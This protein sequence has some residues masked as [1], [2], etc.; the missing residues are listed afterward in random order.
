M[1]RP[2]LLVVDRDLD[3]LARTEGELARRFGADFRVRGESD[4]TVALEQLRLAA[5]RRDPV[6]LVLADPWL[7][8]VGGAELLRSV[9]TLHPD[10]ARALLVP[11]GAWA[12]RRTADEILRG[13][14][15]GDIDYY[16]LEPWSSPDE[17]FCRTVSEFVQVWSR[18]VENRRREVVVV[19]AAREPRGHAV[20]SLLTRNGIPHAYLDRGTP[21]AVAVLRSVEAPEPTSEDGPLVIWLAALGGRVLLDPTDV[22]ICRAWG[23]GT[24]L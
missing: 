15:H 16:V 12:D 3:A 1:A 20:R 7:P 4:S 2:L 22:E 21:E 10:A 19:G 8:G 24:D 6:A 11:W 23:I 17:L 9:R 13:M 14:S 5:E 18:T